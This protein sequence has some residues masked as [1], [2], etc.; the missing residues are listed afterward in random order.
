[1]AV[2]GERETESDQSNDAL[3]HLGFS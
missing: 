3:E 2:S 1:L